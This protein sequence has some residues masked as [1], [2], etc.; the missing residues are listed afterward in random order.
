MEDTFVRSHKEKRVNEYRNSG[1]RE[2]EGA[3]FTVSGNPAVFV[4]PNYGKGKGFRQ[5]N[6]SKLHLNR[7]LH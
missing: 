6:L 4:V 7:I 2:E 3:S 5:L 1:K